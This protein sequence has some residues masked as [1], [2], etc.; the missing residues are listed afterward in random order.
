MPA[1]VILAALGL[2]AVLGGSLPASVRL[3]PLS[4]PI[5]QFLTAFPLYL[6]VGGPLGEE[7]G[8]RG[9]ALPRLLRRQ[10]IFWSGLIIGMIWALWHLPLFW[11]PSSGSGSGWS[12]FVWFFFQLTGWSLMLAWLYARTNGNLL[13]CVLFHAAINT[14]FS[15][16]LP[17]APMYA[18]QNQPIMLTDLVIWCVACAIVLGPL[19]RRAKTALG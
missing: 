3:S 5:V 8:W 1:A 9:Y 4:T 18:G 15:A 12:D 10:S 2:N 14:T 16:V 7:L 6:F 17:V 13:L 11:V 19:G